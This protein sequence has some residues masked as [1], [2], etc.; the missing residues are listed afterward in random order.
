M[1]YDKHYVTTN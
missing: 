1:R